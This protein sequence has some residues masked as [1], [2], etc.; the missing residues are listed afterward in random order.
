MSGARQGVAPPGGGSWASGLVCSG[1]G[2]RAALDRP[3]GLSPAGAPWLVEYRLEPAAGEAWWRALTGRPWSLWR[4][5]ELLPLADP[6]RR[7]D[8]GEGGTP[9]LALARCAPP[10]RT[11]WVKEESGNPTGSFK[12]RGL[13]VAVSRAR[14]LGAPG[15]E[16]ASAGNAA[17]AVA[18]YAAAAGLPCRVALPEDSPP[19]ILERCRAHGAEVLTGPG[20]LAEVA[21]LLRARP[22]D[23]WD[24]STL[25]E[26]WRVEGKKTLLLELREQLGPRL[27]DWIVYPTGGGTGIVGMAKA[28]GELAALDLVEGRAPRFAAVQMAGC[29]PLVRA[30]EAG[31]LDAEPWERPA[32]RVWGLRVPRPLGGPLV[33][34]ALRETDGRALAVEEG[35][36][37]E[38]RARLAR[39]EGLRFGPE[40]AAAFLAMEELAARGDFAPG[41]SA[42]VFQTGHPD[43]Y[44]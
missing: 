40:G 36:L 41:Q 18:A 33:L 24:L 5:R 7:V 13:A 3:P 27:P 11:V 21:G 25:R 28:W 29:A 20:T 19:S 10:E 35:R 17:I 38:V 26:P 9:L 43:N 34:A 44:R 39:H 2:A 31:R 8:L 23:F 22:R 32:T 12:A 6:G 37:E 42:V 30:F 1:T 4:Y 16:L 15:V 14:E